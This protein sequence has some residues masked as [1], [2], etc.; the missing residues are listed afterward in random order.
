MTA[1]DTDNI[2]GYFIAATV[3]IDIPPPINT[4]RCQIID[5][6]QFVSSSVDRASKR[7][8]HDAVMAKNYENR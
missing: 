3:C 6:I 4:H 2:D 1:T 5:T 7:S 8:M